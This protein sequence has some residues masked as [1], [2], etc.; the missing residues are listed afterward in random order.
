MTFV[1]NRAIE[2]PMCVSYAMTGVYYMHGF[3]IVINI[4]AIVS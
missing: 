1:L 4:A 3:P 2:L